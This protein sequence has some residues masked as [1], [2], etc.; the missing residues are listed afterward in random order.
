[1]SKNKKLNSAEIIRETL[2]IDVQEV[3][4]TKMEKEKV[5]Q[6]KEVVKEKAIETELRE[7]VKGL[8]TEKKEYPSIH[9]LIQECGY[10]SGINK[11]INKIVRDL[12]AEGFLKREKVGIRVKI[13][14]VE[15]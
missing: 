11:D 13:I 5:E 2:A 15:K 14:K 6:P 7:K 1:M 4:P 12:E 8:V 3:E 9:V 10:K